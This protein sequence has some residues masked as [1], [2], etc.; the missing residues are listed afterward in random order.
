MTFPIHDHQ[1]R[2]IAAFSG[3][4]R[5]E[6]MKPEV[7]ALMRSRMAQISEAISRRLGRE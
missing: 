7:H 5:V 6:K 2:V 4:G 1:G 3:T